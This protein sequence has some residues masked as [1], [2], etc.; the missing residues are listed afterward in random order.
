MKRYRITVLGR[1]CNIA[2]EKDDSFMKKVESRIN[3]DLKNLQMSMPHADMLDLCVVYLLLLYE[4]IDTLEAGQEK[5]RRS[6][7]EAR[8]I[9]STLEWE[10]ARE[11]T[12]LTKGNKL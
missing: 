8:K 2:T 6:C 1:T 7:I 11:L 12:S 3:S 5:I 9:I 4:R 10:I